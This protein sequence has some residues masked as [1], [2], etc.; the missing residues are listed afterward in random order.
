MEKPVTL[1]SFTQEMECQTC[2]ETR[3]LLEETNELSEALALEVVDFVKG[4]ETA[5][6][7]GIERIPAIVV[8]GDRD[9][10]IRF[11]GIPA[12]YE[13]AS[14]LEDILSVSRRDSGLSDESRERLRGVSSPLHIQVFVTPT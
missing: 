9:Y 4:K 6:A 3:Q 1:V 13:Y 5:D 12:G 2:R 10:G 8:R 11:Y 14:L 7:Y